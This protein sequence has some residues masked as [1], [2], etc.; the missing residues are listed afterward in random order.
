MIHGDW[1]IEIPTLGELLVTRDGTGS[2]CSYAEAAGLIEVCEVQV[3]NPTRRENK[4]EIVCVGGGL[5]PRY[6]KGRGNGCMCGGP[7]PRDTGREGVMMVASRA[8]AER[9][10]QGRSDD[11]GTC[12]GSG[13]F[14]NM[15]FLGRPSMT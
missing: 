15:K 13:N 2:K 8:G 4:I 12:L 7:V 10:W 6:W 14:P 3:E 5:A 9:Y 1:Y 11:G